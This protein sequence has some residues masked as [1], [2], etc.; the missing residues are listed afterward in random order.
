[1]LYPNPQNQ[2]PKISEKAWVSETA[3]IV[4]DVTIGD[5]VY[6]AHNAIIRADEPGSSIIIEDNCNVQDN[7]ILHALSNSE[8]IIER[9]TSLAHGCIVHGPCTLGHG[10]FI[11]FGAVV[12]DCTIGNDVLVL[13]NATVRAVEIPSGKVVF[14]GQV[15]TKQDDVETLDEITPDLAKF[16]NSVINANIKLVDGYKDLAQEA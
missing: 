10:C 1:M 14:D 13:H 15:V 8:V 12:F 3:I 11:G 16:K 9:D 6:V 4:G 5:N 2:H 7:V